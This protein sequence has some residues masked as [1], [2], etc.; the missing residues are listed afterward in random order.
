MAVLTLVAF[1]AVIIFLEELAHWF[2][3][4]D[5]F[6]QIRAVITFLAIALQEVDAHLLLHFAWVVSVNNCV[7]KLDNFLHAALRQLIELLLSHCILAS[8]AHHLLLLRPVIV[9]CEPLMIARVLLIVVMLATAAALL[10]FVNASLVEASVVV[11][12]I[13]V[14]AAAS[15][16]LHLAANSLSFVIVVAWVVTVVHL[17]FVFL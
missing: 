5:I 3:L 11:R 13:A 10:I 6:M 12:L 9:L 14:V 17:C 16:H 7:M 8:R 4:F 2:S 15:R 1:A